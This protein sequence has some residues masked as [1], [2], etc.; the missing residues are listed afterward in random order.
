MLSQRGCAMGMVQQRFPP[1]RGAPLATL[2]F[3]SQFAGQ[4]IESWRGNICSAGLDVLL[5]NSKD[6]RENANICTRSGG[7]H[8]QKRKN[9]FMMW[10]SAHEVVPRSAATPRAIRHRLD[11]ISVLDGIRRFSRRR[12]CSHFSFLHTCKNA[13]T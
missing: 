8:S 1:E 5:C 6:M 12:F 3:A 9:K 13:K 4:N 11:C 10:S 7:E 2:L